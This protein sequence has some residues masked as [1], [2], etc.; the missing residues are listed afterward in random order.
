MK[1]KREE[2]PMDAT[3]VGNDSIKNSYQEA[4]DMV[5]LEKSQAELEREVALS[6][7]QE[8]QERVE[9]LTKKAADLSA[10]EKNLKKLLGEEVEENAAPQPFIITIPAIPVPN[11]QPYIT[12]PNTGPWD[13]SIGSGGIW[14]LPNSV[15]SSPWD[16]QT[17]G[18]WP[19]PCNP[20]ITYERKYVGNTGVINDNITCGGTLNK[21]FSSYAVSSK[22]LT[23]AMIS[24][25]MSWTSSGSA[26]A[27][28]G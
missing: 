28:L 23:D 18:G 12:T 17:A 5:Q 26:S 20:T 3:K 13:P 11:N 4:L 19:Q 10:A 25:H 8:L 27:Q 7:I 15:P 16:G 2:T 6:E 21:D 14:T 1:K 22:D 24:G 9:A